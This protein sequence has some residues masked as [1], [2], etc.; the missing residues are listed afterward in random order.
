M[1]SF[2]LF[3]WRIFCQ[4]RPGQPGQAR[5]G[6]PDQASQL[7]CIPHRPLC[8][9]TVL[10][11]I[12][13][14]AA[15]AHYIINI[16]EKANC[17]MCYFR[18][19]SLSF[20]FLFL[21]IWPGHQVRSIEQL[22]PG[23]LNGLRQFTVAHRF[24]HKSQT[25]PPVRKFHVRKLSNMESGW[26][27]ACDNCAL[28]FLLNQFLLWIGVNRAKGCAQRLGVAFLFLLKYQLNGMVQIS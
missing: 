22:G 11:I 21:F 19:V 4:A 12:N 23:F 17:C 25:M 20:F 2:I 3:S 15:S 18:D 8:H 5:P 26:A 16:S 6:Q 10:I 9:S 13:I 28:L 14:V 24:P 27:T 1:V 7:G